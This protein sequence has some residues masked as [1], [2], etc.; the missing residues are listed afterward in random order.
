MKYRIPHYYNPIDIEKLTGVLRKYEGVHHQQIIADF[1]EAIQKITGAKYV[2]ALNSGTAAIHLGLKLLGVTFGDEVLVPTFTYVASVNPILYLG[3]KPIFI[4]SEP[5]TWNMD[6]QLLEE[7]IKERMK[8]GKTPKAIIVVH[9]YGMPALMD[10]I[11]AVA[12]KYNILVLEDAAEA[13]GS[14]YQN[15]HVGTLG[16]M[17][18]LSFNNNKVVTTFGGGVLLTNDFEKAGKARFLA[19]HSRADKPEYHHEEMGY[20]YRMGPLNAAMGLVQIKDLHDKVNRQR[21]IFNLYKAGLEELGVDFQNES[22][23]ANSNRWISTGILKNNLIHRSFQHL[24][25]EGIEC[26]NVWMPMHMQPVFKGCEAYLIG[27]SESLF[28][29]GFCLPSGP[30]IM[31]KNQDLILRQISRLLTLA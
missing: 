8:N 23:G 10:K 15:K 24:E 13:I 20:N 11:L 19:N 2:V 29:K 31:G 18:V 21:Q 6:P 3:A 25:N 16:E 14:T 27:T 4:D 17:G 28:K 9:I 1:E 7:A 22:D 5:G 26:R 12:K 30:G